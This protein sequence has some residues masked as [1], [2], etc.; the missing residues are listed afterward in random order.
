MKTSRTLP[1]SAYVE[2]AEASAALIRRIE[3]ATGLDELTGNYARLL[4]RVYNPNGNAPGKLLAFD[5]PDFSSTENPGQDALM[6]FQQKGDGTLRYLCARERRAIVR[7][8]E[9][10][11]GQEPAWKL[12]GRY[13]IVAPSD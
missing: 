2:E 9:R 13:G 8:E 1:V 12:K 6:I 11:T 3:A 5:H 10:S 7:D 4:G